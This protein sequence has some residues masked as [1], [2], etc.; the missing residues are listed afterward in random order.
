MAGR[1][2]GGE[3]VAAFGAVLLLVSLLV[4]HWYGPQTRVG[5]P[6]LPSLGRR[7]FPIGALTGWRAI[8]T[9]RWFGLLTVAL[10]LALA[11]AQA[12]VR[13]PALPATLDLIAMLVAGLTTLLLVIRLATT[14]APL[15]FGAVVGLLAAGA[16]TFG[17]FRA[18]RTEQGAVP[19]PGHP[20]ELVEL[21]VSPRG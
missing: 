19:E 10:G 2:R 1:L 5:P 4:L 6:M 17:A 16:V 15:R 21:S 8:P 13:G 18:L 3:W 11:L 7:L 14:D 20:V 9:L 12:L